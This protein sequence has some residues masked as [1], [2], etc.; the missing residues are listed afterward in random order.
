MKK[1][2]ISLTTEKAPQISPRL[3][4]KTGSVISKALLFNK[5]EKNPAVLS[6]SLLTFAKISL[7]SNAPKALRFISFCNGEVNAN[8]FVAV[9]DTVETKLLPNS[10]NFFCPAKS[11]NVK[12][13]A[14]IP[15][16]LAI[17]MGLVFGVIVKETFDVVNAFVDCVIAD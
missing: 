2:C 15:A 8:A 5:F 14:K 7:S 16:A 1:F 9:P 17:S 6:S 12:L 10:C 11:V 4:P 3:R 13:S